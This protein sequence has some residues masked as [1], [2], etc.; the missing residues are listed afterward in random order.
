MGRRYV[1]L[2]WMLTVVLP[3]ATVACV[4][5]KST[6]D[7]TSEAGSAPSDGGLGASGG[8]TS[9]PPRHDDGGDPTGASGASG[10][11]NSQGGNDNSTGGVA[12]DASL[13][14]ALGQGGS[15]AGAAAGQNGGG[16]GG[17]AVSRVCR[18]WGTDCLRDWDCPANDYCAAFK[19]APAPA[20]GTPC[21]SGRCG[22]GARCVSGQCQATVVISEG[23][24]CDCPTCQC[25]PGLVC[26]WEDD[27]EFCKQAVAL[28]GQ[29]CRSTPCEQGLYCHEILMISPPECRRRGVEGE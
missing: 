12:G 9:D 11:S 20:A 10:N 7:D 5:D 27:A 4:D 13:A 21:V 14:G 1:F 3:L 18:A 16:D 19:C 29:S 23:E 17:L 25:A 2:G 6:G 8:G 22:P 15:T 28:E 26:D 24:R